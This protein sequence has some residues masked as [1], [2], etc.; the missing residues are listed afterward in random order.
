MFSYF[1]I[2]IHIYCRLPCRLPLVL[3]DNAAT[4]L[5]VVFLLEVSF[6]PLQTLFIVIYSASP[7]LFV[8]GLTVAGLAFSTYWLRVWLNWGESLIKAN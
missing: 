4:L 5:S 1:L 3:T 7:A 2:L 8:K 6:S